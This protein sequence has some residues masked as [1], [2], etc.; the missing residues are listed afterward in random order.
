MRCFFSTES[1]VEQE[2][3]HALELEKWVLAGDA[4]ILAR[5]VTQDFT[6]PF[7]QNN[8][9]LAASIY[10]LNVQDADLIVQSCANE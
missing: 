5:T 8:A 6:H 9:R 4:L 7:S 1:R 3:L 2:L 10:C